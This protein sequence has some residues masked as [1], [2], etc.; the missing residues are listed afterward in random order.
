VK[1]QKRELKGIGMQ[2]TEENFK[3]MWLNPSREK[4]SAYENRGGGIIQK[5]RKSSRRLTV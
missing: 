1:K 4:S 2:G 5:V 3:E